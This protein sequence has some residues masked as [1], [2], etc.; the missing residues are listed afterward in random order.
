MLRQYFC[1]DAVQMARETLVTPVGDLMWAKVLT[2]G[3]QNAG[4]ASEKE[5]YSIELLMPKGDADAQAFATK[6]K[7]LFMEEHG[8]AARPGQ[9]GLPFKTYLNEKGEETDLWKFSF[10][11]N[12]TTKRGNPVG[13]PVVQD[14]KG[15]PWPTDLLIG[16]G[17]TGKVAFTYYSW[18]SPEGG[19]GL[20]LQLEAVRVLTLVEYTAPNHAAAFGDAEEGF[21]LPEQQPADEF[22]FGDPS[23]E[24]VPF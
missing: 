10:N 4:K 1:M 12:T 13:P 16:N 2:P 15:K 24:E 18:D 21:E 23:E 22:G 20:S 5:A 19:K 11:R 8:N 14:A 17:S 9:N 3:I 7:K 6:I